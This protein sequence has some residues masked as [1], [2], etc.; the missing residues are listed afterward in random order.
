[1]DKYQ[2]LASGAS[3]D[4][5]YGIDTPGK[6]GE[7]VVSSVL[8][9]DMSVDG[10]DMREIRGIVET[11]RGVKTQLARLTPNIEGLALASR[12]QV[13]SQLRSLKPFTEGLPI[14]MDD[15]S[16]LSDDLEQGLKKGREII[17]RRLSELETRLDKVE[18]YYTKDGQRVTGTEDE[19]ISQQRAKNTLAMFKSLGQRL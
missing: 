13:L 5:L 15:G 4:F 18:T 2:K 14:Q 1:L 7:I 12:L 10:N 6:G 3:D 16:T 9:S 17:L 11:R 8:F 19:Q